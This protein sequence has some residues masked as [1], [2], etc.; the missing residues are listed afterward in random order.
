MF[1]S[2]R[3]AGYGKSSDSYFLHLVIEAV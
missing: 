2:L 1:L 3:H